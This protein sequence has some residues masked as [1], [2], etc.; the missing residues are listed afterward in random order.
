MPSSEAAQRETSPPWVSPLEAIVPP[1]S[2]ACKSAQEHRRAR[3]TV[4]RLESTVSLSVSELVRKDTLTPC[5]VK[6]ST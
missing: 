4:S 1:A 5:Q 6:K 3:M 2:T